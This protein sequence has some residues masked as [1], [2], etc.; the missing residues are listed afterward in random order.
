MA[1]SVPP[2]RAV[3]YTFYT[4]LT[5]QADVKLFQVAPTLAAGD[6]V[7]IKD[8]VLDDN[9]DTLPVAVTSATRVIAVALS[10]AEMTADSVA[11]IF[12][13]AAGAEWCDLV[14][15]IHTVTSKQIDDIPAAA[16]S[17]ATI[18]DAVLDEAV[19]GHTGVLALL[20]GGEAHH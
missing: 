3:A 8:G 16:P 10:V 20:P 1:S 14:I 6:V 18:A 9:I 4:S 7:I 12:H 15:D 2:K 5:S 13:D 17:A 19:A 11:V